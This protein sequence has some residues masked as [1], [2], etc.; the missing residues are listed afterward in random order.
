MCNLFQVHG[1][2]F[3]SNWVVLGEFRWIQ[4]VVQVHGDVK[5]VKGRSTWECGVCKACKGKDVMGM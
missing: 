3:G 2:R 5:L 1:F 4:L